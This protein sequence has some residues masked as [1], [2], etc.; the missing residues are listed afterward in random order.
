MPNFSTGIP[1][2]CDR[3]MKRIKAL[4]VGGLVPWATPVETVSM[5]SQLLANAIRFGHGSCGFIASSSTEAQ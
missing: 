1:D 4:E 3:V 2:N 5:A